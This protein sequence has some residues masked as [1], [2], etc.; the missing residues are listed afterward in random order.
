V[1]T[2]GKK[3]KRTSKKN[4]DGRYTSCHEKKTFRSRSVVKI[5]GVDGLGIE[6]RWEIRFSAPLQ[7]SP[8]A[9]PASSTMGT[10]SFPG[11][12]RPGRGVDLLSRVTSRF[13]KE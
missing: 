1:D 11:V 4:V 8:G 7:T 6:S 13:K 3:E 5:Y 2:R 9:Q 12:K 10:G